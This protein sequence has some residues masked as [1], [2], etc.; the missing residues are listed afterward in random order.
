MSGSL[1]ERSLGSAINN[2]GSTMNGM[3]N[4]PAPQIDPRVIQAIIASQAQPMMMPQGYGASRFL[5][6]DTGIPLNYGVD[7]P[8]YT[9]FSMT[10]GSFR[11]FMSIQDFSNSSNPVIPVYDPITRTYIASQTGVANDRPVPATY[12]QFGTSGGDGE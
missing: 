10:P 6:G 9:P 12:N 5:T 2:M 8:A 7:A 1:I 11:D 3:G 4:Q